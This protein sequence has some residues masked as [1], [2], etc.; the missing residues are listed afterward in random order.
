MT[1]VRLR[2]LDK[3]RLR[4]IRDR[5][6]VVV[7]HT[8]RPTPG[9]NSRPGCIDR[10][11]SV[12][13]RQRHTSGCCSA[14]T[15]HPKH[16]FREFHPWTLSRSACNHRETSDRSVCDRYNSHSSL[17]ATNRLRV[18]SWD[19]ALPPS[20]AHTTL[21]SLLHQWHRPYRSSPEE[22]SLHPGEH[23][24]SLRL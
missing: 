4:D 1:S 18:S 3:L 20:A 10:L 16:L 8:N 23:L 6:C 5:T 19:Q 24:T 15:C 22:H 17:S 7:V 14:H 11:H 9:Q 12:A 13:H 2:N 21:Q